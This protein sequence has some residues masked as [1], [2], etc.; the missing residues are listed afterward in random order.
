MRVFCVEHVLEGLDFVLLLN[1]PIRKSPHRSLRRCYAF[2]YSLCT[3]GRRLLRG[4]SVDGSEAAS[5]ADCCPHSHWFTTRSVLARKMQALTWYGKAG[6]VVRSSTGCREA[7]AFSTMMHAAPNLVPANTVRT[8]T[9]ARLLLC[10]AGLHCGLPGRC[11]CLPELHRFVP[12]QVKNP[13]PPRS[14]R[15]GL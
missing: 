14:R 3:L 8:D 9:A 5:T 11:I 4:N 10:D 12:T 7:G 13:Q 2:S 1:R 15:Q 6:I